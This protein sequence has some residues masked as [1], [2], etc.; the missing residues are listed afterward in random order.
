MSKHKVYRILPIPVS[1]FVGAPQLSLIYR[2]QFRIHGVLILTHYTVHF[3]VRIVFVPM[4]TSISEPQCTGVK[5]LA[6]K[7][8]NMT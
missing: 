3:I 6:R 4:T 7:G 2:S 1:G 8:D 5:T